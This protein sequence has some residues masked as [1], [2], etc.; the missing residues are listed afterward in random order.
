MES[1]VWKV[2]RVL[3]SELGDKEYDV[4][5]VSDRVLVVARDVWMRVLDSELVYEEDGV[6][7]V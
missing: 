6:S 7:V 5:I 2:W 1:D 4:S 3:D